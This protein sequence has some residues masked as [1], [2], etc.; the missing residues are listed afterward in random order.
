MPATQM[1]IFDVMILNTPKLTCT[2]EK[3]NHNQTPV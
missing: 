1:K 2:A 3:R